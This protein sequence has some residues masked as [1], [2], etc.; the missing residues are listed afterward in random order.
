MSNFVAMWVGAHSQDARWVGWQRGNWADGVDTQIGGGPQAAQAGT[1]P[2][3]RSHKA[4]FVRVQLR[5]DW[6]L[7]A[8][9]VSDVVIGRDEP[10]AKLHH[11]TTCRYDIMGA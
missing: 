3:T 11:Q 2:G 4:F 9:K 6:K 10:W 1:R 5:A 8:G 7:G